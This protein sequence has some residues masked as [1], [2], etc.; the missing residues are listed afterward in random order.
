MLRSKYK[1]PDKCRAVFFFA[2][3]RGAPGERGTPRH[4]KKKGKSIV[5]RCR[6]FGKRQARLHYGCKADNA[7]G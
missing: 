6:L 1:P 4:H 7:L 3:L 2:E 5:L